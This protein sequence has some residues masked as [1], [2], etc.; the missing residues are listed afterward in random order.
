MKEKIC[1]VVDCAWIYEVKIVHAI[2]GTRRVGQVNGS[3][4]AE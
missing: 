2:E 4:A 1:V 3:M